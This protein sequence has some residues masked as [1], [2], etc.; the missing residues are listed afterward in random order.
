[1]GYARRRQDYYK[2]AELANALELHAA[3]QKS[4]VFLGDNTSAYQANW[5][6]ALEDLVK[7]NQ[8]DFAF[9]DPM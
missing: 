3:I 9:F 2:T 4:N 1:L 5:K 7:D 6:A 8:G